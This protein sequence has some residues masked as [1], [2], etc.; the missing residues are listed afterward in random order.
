MECLRD[1]NLAIVDVETSGTHFSSS[2][3]IEI[4]VLRIE[5]GKCR[6]TFSTTIN[7]GM[8]VPSWITALTGITQEEV[9]GAPRFDEVI[10]D[11]D[12]LLQDAIFVAHNVSFDYSFIESE[13]ARAG[14]HFA[15]HRLCTVR[16]SRKLFPQMR[17]HSLSHLIDRHGLFTMSRHRAFDDAYALWQ[18]MQL[19]QRH[20][21]GFEET[22]EKLVNKAPVRFF[23]TDDEEPVIR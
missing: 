20:H 17:R 18:F 9:S 2:R 11:I 8:T 7:P 16:L 3:V 23:S 21:P 19:C 15:P 1:K 13:F 10:D 12:R 14:R 5:Q 22:F 4:G 6:E